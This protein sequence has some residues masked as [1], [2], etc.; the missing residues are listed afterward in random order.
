MTR[1]TCVYVLVRILEREERGTIPARWQAIR[2]SEGIL[3]V[4]VGFMVAPPPPPLP[5]PLP[6]LPLVKEDDDSDVGD[7]DVARKYSID[8]HEGKTEIKNFLT[9]IA[10]LPLSLYR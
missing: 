1:R 2:V 3:I 6:P 9:S 8:N 5:P 10:S 7:N 4:I